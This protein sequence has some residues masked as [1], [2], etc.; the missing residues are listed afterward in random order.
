V[1]VVRL[2]L[3]DYAGIQKV[4]YPKV[5]EAVNGSTDGEGCDDR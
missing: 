5:K 1:E 4:K 3:V 2:E